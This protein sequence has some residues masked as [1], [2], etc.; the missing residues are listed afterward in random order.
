MI[1]VLICGGRDC[2]DAFNV[3]ERDMMVEIEAALLRPVTISKIVHGGARGADE[4]AG[5]WAES[6]GIKSVAVPADWKKHGKAAG[7]IRN[8][9]MLI[10]H[11]PDIVVALPGGRGTADMIRASEEFGVPVVRIGQWA[12]HPYQKENE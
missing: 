8:R 9:R 1:T 10:D 7:P 2:L 6:E 5:R 3:I 12:H 11:S 4:D